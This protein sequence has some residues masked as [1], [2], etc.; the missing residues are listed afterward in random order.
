MKNGEKLDKAALLTGSFPSNRS[1]WTLHGIL[2][3]DL[4]RKDRVRHHFE[5][6]CQAVD[7]HFV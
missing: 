7:C 4:T 6:A 3:W 1:G 2:L 5:L